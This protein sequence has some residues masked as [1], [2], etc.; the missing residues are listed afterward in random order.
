MFSFFFFLPV[1]FYSLLLLLP[2]LLLSDLFRIL[3]DLPLLL[4]PVLL[5]GC[6]CGAKLISDNLKPLLERIRKD[7]RKGL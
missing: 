3:P 1:F 6:R 4:I 7:L 5:A 2:H